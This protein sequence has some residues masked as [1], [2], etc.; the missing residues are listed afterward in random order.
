MVIAEQGHVRDFWSFQHE[1]AKRL[2]TS[3][4]DTGVAD[5]SLY[6]YLPMDFKPAASFPLLAKILLG[7]VLV[8][9]LGMGLAAW[10]IVRR[11][12]RRRIGK[13]DNVG[14]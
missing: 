5:D 4:F 2:L 10:R 12:R 14:F 6:T 1:A 8:L 7:V 9:T 3:S 13:K 11:L